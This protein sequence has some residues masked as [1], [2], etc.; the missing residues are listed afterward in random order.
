[1]TR[2][3]RVIEAGAVLV[4]S[5]AAAI[6]FTWPLVLHLQTRARDLADTLFQAWTIDWVQHAIE[7]GKNVYDAN[8]FAPEK[9]SLAFSDTLF[10]VAI[11]TLPLRWLG[12]TPIGVLNVTMILGFTVSAAAAYLFVRLVTGSRV[13]GAVAGAV[14][15]FGP[16]GALATR[17]VHV[18]VRPG[19]PLA[20]AAAWWL[21]D[22]ARDKGRLVAPAF[23]LI[24]VVAW[25]ATVSFYPATYAVVA[26]GLVLVVR[27]R[28]LDRRGIVAG[29]GALAGAVASLVLLAIPN[30]EVAARD[31]N[32]NF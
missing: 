9:T 8:T 1:M 13:A 25:Q 15:A 10:G 27:V 12:L 32:Y 21:A 30:L 17:H 28:S 31:P 7:S 5:L 6:A 2:R 16:F 23:A 26:A 4:G 3:G 29:L 18:A 14:Y 22:R 11:P 19:V 20:A 24:A